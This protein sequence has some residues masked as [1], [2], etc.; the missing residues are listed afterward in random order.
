[1]VLFWG[2]IVA[3]EVL[4]SVGKYSSI[5]QIFHFDMVHLRPKLNQDFSVGDNERYGDFISVFG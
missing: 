4:I 2:S 5:K 1:M 3:K